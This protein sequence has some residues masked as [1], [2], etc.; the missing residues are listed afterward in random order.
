MTNTTAT[1]GK[2][3]ANHGVPAE[4]VYGYAQAIKIG[5]RSMCPAS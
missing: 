2:E 1:T 5:T 3:A 4:D